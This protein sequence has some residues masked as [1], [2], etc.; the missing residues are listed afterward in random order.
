MRLKAR[1]AALAA[2]VPPGSVVADIG[3]DHAYLPVY[4]IRKGLAGRVIAVEKRPKTMEGARRTLAEYD[5]GGRI[6]L[7]CGDGLGPLRLEDGVDCV[8][9]AGMGGRTICRILAKS[10]EKL[11]WFDRFLLQPMQDSVLL[12]R[13]LVANGMC[14]SFEKLARE[15][16]HIYEIMVVKRGKQRIFNSLLY[17]LGPCLLRDGDPLLE[18]FIGKKIRRCRSMIESLDRS[19]R[20]ECRLK[21]LHF[22]DK[23]TRL[24]EVL[25]LVGNCADN[26]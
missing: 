6:E 7:R 21:R 19:G 2:F 5:H 10:R 24:K 1:L 26:R 16:G 12:R 23:E 4:L 3:T 18:P 15:G 8:V 20:R 25:A 9:I 22:E 14:F 17:E 13:W 11:D